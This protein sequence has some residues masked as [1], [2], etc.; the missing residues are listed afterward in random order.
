MNKMITENK[1]P[2]QFESVE[3]L[4]RQGHS[5]VS[6]NGKFLYDQAPGIYQAFPY[7]ELSN[8]SSNDL[9]DF[10]RQNKALA[11]RYSSP[12]NSKS[13]KLSYHVVCTQKNYDLTSISKKPRRDVRIGLD[14]A[15]YEPIPISRLATEGWNLRFETLVRQGRTNAESK[16]TWES[17]CTSADGLPGFEAW[18]ALHGDKLVASLLCYKVQD[19][20]SILYQQSSTGHLKFGVNNALT[21]V[22][23]HEMMHRPDVESIFYGVES[24]DAPPTVDKYK[25]RMGYVAKP[26]LQRVVFNPYIAPF[27][28]KISYKLL[29]LMCRF[30]STSILAKAKGML[31]FYLQGKYSLYEQSWPEA[32]LDQ[33]ESILGS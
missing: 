33:R 25:F 10:F 18:G 21:F 2:D 15:S 4:H 1:V 31:R 5:V 32:L 29:E 17:L 16:R 24:L 6:I 9:R 20:I 7:H 28:G 11:L 27:M 12:L 26:V 19:T 3:W 14:Y 13:G 30:F 8:F 22:V 23:T